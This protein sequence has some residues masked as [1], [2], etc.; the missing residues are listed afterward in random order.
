MV[1]QW[2]A[3]VATVVF[4]LGMVGP[5]LAAEI[6]GA[7][8]AVEDDGAYIVV[9][10]KDGK[11]VKLRI[12]S[13]ATDLTKGGKPIGRKAVKVGDKVKVVYDEKD[14]RKTASKIEVQ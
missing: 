6:A 3:L 10:D 1:R 7:I 8:S 12:S 14:A 4:L 2:I 11:E 9:K 5:I 13:S